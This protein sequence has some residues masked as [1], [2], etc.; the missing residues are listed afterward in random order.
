MNVNVLGTEYNI[1]Y[2][3]YEEDQEFKEN[4]LVGYCSNNLKLIA[5]CNMK[6]YPG[7][8]NSSEEEIDYFQKHTLRH[9]IVHAFFNESGL[10]H[11][12]NQVEA[13]WAVNEEMVDWIASQGV[14]IHKAWKEVGAL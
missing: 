4:K 7:W 14:K 1:V 11:S 13:P 12:S 6:T 2:K 9:E 5:V 8:Q 10:Y 3:D